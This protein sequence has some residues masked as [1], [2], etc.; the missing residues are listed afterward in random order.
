V[1]CASQFLF[2]DLSQGHV[3]D[4]PT[5][6]PLVFFGASIDRSSR[7][8]IFPQLFGPLLLRFFSLKFPLLENAEATG[9]ALQKPF[10]V[11]PSPYRTSAGSSLFYRQLKKSFVFFTYRP[12]KHRQVPSPVFSSL[13]LHLL[14]GNNCAFLTLRSILN[15]IPFLPA[16]TGFFGGCL[17]F[18]FCCRPVF[19]APAGP[20]F[21]P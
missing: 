3:S 8:E 17:V 14:C 2:L 16:V 1:G 21:P 11:P 18:F 15:L 6:S 4:P 20:Q 12:P 5:I 19:F 9:L 7:L 10:L 13:L